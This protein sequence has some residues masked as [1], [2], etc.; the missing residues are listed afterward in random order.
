MKA[1]GGLI[2]A[3]L[4]AAGTVLAPP[5]AMAQSVASERIRECTCLKLE[6]EQSRREIDLQAGMIDERQG[7]L[8][9]LTHD[10]DALRPRI[11]PEDL[12]AV[13]S[14]KRMLER[15]QAL[16]SFLQREL[17]PIQATRISDFNEAVGFFNSNC[18]GAVPKTIP[19]DLQ[20]SDF[21]PHHMK[22]R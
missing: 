7:E 1:Y 15:Q 6:I 19:A 20:C 9:A 22:S 14:F 13:E 4:L 21:P 5:S 8:E 3:C 11:N 16:R 18:I 10:I 2:V 12:A 17:R